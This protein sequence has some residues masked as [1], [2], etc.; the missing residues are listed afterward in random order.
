MCHHD[1]RAFWKKVKRKWKDIATTLSNV[2]II[3]KMDLILQMIR[4][5]YQD[6]KM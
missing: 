3:C 2:Y 6:Q 1:M 4:G 5:A